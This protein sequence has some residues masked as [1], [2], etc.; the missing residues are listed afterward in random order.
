MKAGRQRTIVGALGVLAVGILASVVTTV[1]I[2][3]RDISLPAAYLFGVGV[4]VVCGVV[5]GLAWAA[6]TWEWDHPD[7]GP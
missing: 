2:R 7:D 3:G 1:V 6:I 5:A 4:G